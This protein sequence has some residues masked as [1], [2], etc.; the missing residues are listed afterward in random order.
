MATTIQTADI[1]LI[2][3]KREEKGTSPSGRLRA[4]GR[5]PAVLYGGDLP[6]VAISVEEKA[7]KEILK[8][9]AG[10][11]TIFLL[12][13]RGTTEERMAM[14][15]ELQTNPISGKF[16]HI[17][18]I[19]V[20]A[21][22]ALTVTIRIELTGDCK[23]VRQGGRIDFM[24]RELSVE[25]LPRHMFD[26][27]EIDTTDMMIGDVITVADLQPRLPESARFLE[28]PARVVVM[29]EAPRLTEAKE[30]EEAAGERVIAETAEPEVIGKGKASDEEA[31]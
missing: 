17:D 10:E 20:M 22:H 31:G 15:K 3:D 28:D 18:F 11:N 4:V 1:T 29:V 6:P 9:E 30:G 5:V 14:I 2:V 21:G 13:L 12:K 25:V 7:V 16:T 19:R 24:S 26:H 8:Q 23:G 27:I